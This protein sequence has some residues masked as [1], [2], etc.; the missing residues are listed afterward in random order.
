MDRR[1]LSLPLQQSSGGRSQRWSW[2]P[3][4]GCP[5][6]S[7]TTRPYGIGLP[8]G[9]EANTCHL[10]GEN[11]EQIL[12]KA[13]VL[14]CITHYL[15]SSPQQGTSQTVECWIC[16]CKPIDAHF[17]AVCFTKITEIP[18]NSRTFVLQGCGLSSCFTGHCCFVSQPNVWVLKTLDTDL[19]HKCY[20]FALQICIAFLQTMKLHNFA[21]QNLANTGLY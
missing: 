18:E 21:L 4:I 10:R 11:P 13:E 19:Q 14:D 12:Y 3:G 6:Q 1:T 9:M 8:S 20:G 15:H 7:T 5:A 2:R 16:I 17:R